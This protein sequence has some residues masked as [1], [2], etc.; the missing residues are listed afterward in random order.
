MRRRDLF[1]R[2]LHEPPS[3][4]DRTSYQVLLRAGYVQHLGSGTFGY[5]PLGHKIL[6]RLANIANEELN[7]SGGTQIQLPLVQSP[8]IWTTKGEN[9]TQITDPNQQL[10]FLNQKL[11]EIYNIGIIQKEP[12]MCNTII[13]YYSEQEGL[14][15]Q[16][17]ELQKSMLKNK[18]NILEHLMREL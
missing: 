13:K 6:N 12:K 1:S 10:M 16:V 7:T 15:D 14:E 8:D 2:T 5:L 17:I 4:A 9:G 18:D 11:D 3:D